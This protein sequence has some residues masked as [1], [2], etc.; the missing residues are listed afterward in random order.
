MRTLWQMM[1]AISIALGCVLTLSACG[2]ET[3]TSAAAVAAAKAQEAQQAKQQM[4]MM[5]AQIQ[6]AAEKE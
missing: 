2:L 3:A 6:S 5:Q 1:R 4:E